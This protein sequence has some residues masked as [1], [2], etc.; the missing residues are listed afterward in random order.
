MYGTNRKSVCSIHFSDCGGRWLHSC[1][2]TP[3]ELADARHIRVTRNHLLASPGPV[4]LKLVAVR[5][6][7]VMARRRTRRPLA[8]SHARTLGADDSRR[9]RKIQC[10]HAPWL[11]PMGTQTKKIRVVVEVFLCDL[12]GIS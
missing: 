7:Q 11:W 12:C 8:S 9:T 1:R 10:R 5:G 4:G 6:P 2:R 3:M